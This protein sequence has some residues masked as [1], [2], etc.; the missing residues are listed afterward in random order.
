MI[1]LV[2]VILLF[3]S[4]ELTD[5]Q[6]Q[7]QRRRFVRTSSKR[8]FYSAPIAYYA[9]HCC[10]FQLLLSGDIETN[11]GPAA[12]CTSCNKTVKVNSKRVECKTCKGLQH[13]KCCKSNAIKV[14]SP[15][16]PATWT[17]HNC[18]L[19]VLPFFRV[20][21]IFDTDVPQ[22]DEQLNPETVNL[23]N[24]HRKHF[25]IAHLNTQSMTPAFNEFESMLSEHQFDIITMSET[26]LK[27]NK[28]LLDHL[29][30]EGYK[31]DFQNRDEKRGGGVGFYL[32]SDIKHKVRKDIQALDNTIEHQWIELTGETKLA[33][34]LIGII[35]QPSSKTKEKIEWLDKF[36]TVLSQITLIHQGPIMIAGDFNIDMLKQSQ[37]RDI[38]QNILDNFNLIQHVTKPTRKSKTLIDHLITSAGTKLIASD[39]VY[40]DEISDHDSPFCIFKITKPR[41]EPRY[42]Y[43]RNERSFILN[44]YLNDF[45]HL[46]LNV[47]Y[48]L[49]DVNEKL[50]IFNELITTCIDKHAPIERVK[51]TR[52]SSPWM[53]D[54]NITELQR[55]RNLLRQLQSENRND[56]EILKEL[57]KVRNELKK[58][59]NTT[60]K[61]FLRKLLSNKNSS[62]TWKVINKV[63]HPKTKRVDVDPDEVNT[64]FNT[65]ATRTTGQQSDPISES[66]LNQLNDHPDNFQLR[67]ATYDEVKKSINLLRADCST[68]YDNI[69]TRYI[70]PVSE[71]LISPLTHIINTCIDHSIFPDDWKISRICPVPKVPNPSALAEYR[72]ISIL[73]V[74][75]KV[76][77]RILLQQLTERIETKSI[78]LEMQSGFRK[79]HSTTTLLL[80][81]RD[82]IKQAMRKGEVTRAIFA[83]FSKAFDTVNYKTLLSHLN[84]LGF[85]KHLLKLVSSYL[86]NRYQYV[87]VDDRISKRLLVNFGV[88]QGSILGP[89][90]FNLY[91]TS[92]NTN[93]DSEYLL[94]ADDTTLLRYSKVKDLPETVEAMQTELNN[95]NQ[96]STNNN[97]ALNATKTKMAMFS[98]AQLSRFHNLS[99]VEAIITSN[100]QPLERVDSFKILGVW[101]NQHLSWKDHI[102]YVTKSCFATLK[103]LNLFKRCASLPLRKTLAESLILS[104]LNY[105]N[106]LLGDLTKIELNRLQKVQNAAAG[107][108]L[109]KHAE[110]DDVLSLKWLPISESIDSSLAKTIHKAVNDKNW[111]S[112]LPIKVSL[113]RSRE[114][115]SNDTTVHNVEPGEANGSFKF[116]GAKCFNVLPTNVKTITKKENFNKKCFEYYF[117]KAVAR[118]LT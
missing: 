98:T 14:E 60:K 16:V 27:Q 82:N 86:S 94:Y 108:V 79:C 90:L 51:I 53:K 77:E 55:K 37:E 100:D 80:K 70:K 89:I 48:G 101:F 35:Y 91:V 85:S 45:R 75:S 50:S 18:L 69:P 43:I 25:S 61:T 88:P 83:D 2:F 54:L 71:Y 110:L 46:P 38:Y 3:S 97:L 78:Y 56:Q 42:K 87:Q 11:P 49:E 59:I 34:I 118:N 21:D 62:E 20:R 13:L 47:V 5:V 72:P 106:V 8:T 29:E 102:N 93:G 30:I 114:H 6:K 92:I 23:L 95:I 28:A 111:P 99:D 32:K 96:W 116:L 104:K 66:F 105:G 24:N 81:L 58:K 84:N 109:Q 10:S 36:E 113:Q 74:L 39:V 15:R 67:H 19:S 41:F 40:C 31:K 9:N 63:L 52:P 4:A 64:F 112:Y 103:S 7:Q 22:E 65:T 26:W 17:C 57:R 115:R 33:N 73:P 1:S 107:F 44:D 12:K 68:G 76:F 117:D